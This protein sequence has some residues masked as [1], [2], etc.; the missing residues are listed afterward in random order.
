MSGLAANQFPIG[1]IKVTK[2]CLHVKA[3]AVVGASSCG[4]NSVFLGLGIMPVGG[5]N[6]EWICEASEQT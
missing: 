4:N 2:Q 1:D 6:P 3:V 5:R